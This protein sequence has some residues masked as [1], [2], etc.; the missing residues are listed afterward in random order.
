M[1]PMRT[2]LHAKHPWT[3]EPGGLVAVLA[4]QSVRSDGARCDTLP[5]RRW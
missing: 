3:A 1:G 5:R 2:T 4:R